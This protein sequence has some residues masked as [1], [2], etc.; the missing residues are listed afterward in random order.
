[1][2]HVPVSSRQ[3]HVKPVRQ[4]HVKPVRQTHVKPVGP[5]EESNYKSM[6]S[7]PDGKQDLAR[8]PGLTESPIEFQWRFAELNS[9]DRWR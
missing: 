9:I 3:T 5:N 6:L 1:M 7:C 8:D 2:S 4:T